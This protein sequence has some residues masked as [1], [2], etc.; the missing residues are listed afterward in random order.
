[1]IG[2]DEIPQEIQG[3][4]NKG[5]LLKLLIVVLVVVS[6]IALWLPPGR[7]FTGSPKDAKE[8][9]EYAVYSAIIR[10]RYFGLTIV[11]K[12]HTSAGLIKDLGYLDESNEEFNWY[13]KKFMGIETETITNFISNNE[14]S[15]PLKKLFKFWVWYTL[16]SDKELDEIFE[17]SVGGGW[18]KFYIL[19]PFSHGFLEFSRPGFNQEM[20]EALVYAG[21]QS[22]GLS[23]AGYIIYLK[24]E[25]GTWKIKNE[26]MVWI[27]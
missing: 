24:K 6:L 21:N 3:A 15:Y 25:N 13:G 8:A 26:V 17:D 10:N 4:K 2:S 7:L 20:N 1:M 11:I 14:R 22:A 16:I 12:D 27:S 19:Y 5:F 23:G 9:E 18:N